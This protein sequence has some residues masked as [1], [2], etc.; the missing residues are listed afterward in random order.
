[1]RNG[2]LGD[3][4]RLIRRPMRTRCLISCPQIYRDLRFISRDYPAAA[5][6][7]LHP[8]LRR[9]LKQVK[10]EGHRIA[11]LSR[12]KLTEGTSRFTQES[13]LVAKLKAIPEVDIFCPEELGF[14]EKLSIWLSHS[15]VV[16]FPQGCL[17]LKPFVADAGHNNVAKQIF[18]VAGPQS[19]PS[20]WLSI[21]KACDFGDFYLDCDGIEDAFTKDEKAEKFTRSNSIN[22]TKIARA[23]QELAASLR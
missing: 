22:V 17:M 8:K 3:R 12:H 6:V 14:E 1:M 16:G 7:A 18:L 23:I 19:L 5:R 4:F 2:L 13:E 10:K 21:E 9:N 11:Y 20:N 15:Y